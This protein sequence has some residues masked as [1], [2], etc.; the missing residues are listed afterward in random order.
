MIN[1]LTAMFVTFREGFEAVFLTMLML[2]AGKTHGMR[3]T[4]ALLGIAAGLLLSMGLVVAVD[5]M[6]ISTAYAQPIMDLCAAI[7]LTYVVIWNAKVTKHIN[8]HLR[9]MRS[10]GMLAMLFTVTAIYFREGAEMAIMLY[11]SFAADPTGSAAGVGVGLVMLAVTVY[12]VRNRVARRIDAKTLFVVSNVVL[13]ALALYFYAEF[14]EA[15]L[16]S[17]ILIQAFQ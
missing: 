12:M 1:S 5:R 7:V 11:G 3:S 6:D 9:E 8:E 10:R 15:L 14:A 13:G 4:T 16:D 17:G 2:G